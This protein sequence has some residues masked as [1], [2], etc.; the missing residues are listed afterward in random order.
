MDLVI[1]IYIYIFILYNFPKIALRKKLD[2][3]EFQNYCVDALQANTKSWFVYLS[4]L[5]IPTF[6]C[7]HLPGKIKNQ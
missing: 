5:F 4:A 7:Y 6:S 2:R 1:R 3:T